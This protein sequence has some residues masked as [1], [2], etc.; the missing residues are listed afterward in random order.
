MQKAT[1]YVATLRK[2]DWYFVQRN[3]VCCLQENALISARLQSC[4]PHDTTKARAHTE[5]LHLI[6]HS[7][8]ETGEAFLL[9]LGFRTK[10]AEHTFVLT[11]NIGC[12]TQFA[13]RTADNL[14]AQL[15][16]AEV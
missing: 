14:D 12:I 8:N 7:F 1:R 9:G 16:L 3:E 6:Q 4:L 10:V 11:G 13:V 5:H 15:M 2:N